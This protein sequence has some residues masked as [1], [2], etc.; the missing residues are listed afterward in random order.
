[1]QKAVVLV[2]TLLGAGTAVAAFLTLAMEMHVVSGTFFV[3]TA[4]AIYVRETRA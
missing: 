3:L 4:F 1:M 2:V